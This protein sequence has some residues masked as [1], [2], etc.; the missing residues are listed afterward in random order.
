M[1]QVYRELYRVVRPGGVLV[2]VVGPYV[3]DGK[4]I[5]LAADT[6][7]LCEAAGWTPRERWRHVKRSVSFWRHLHH[8]RDP[9]APVV[10]WEDVLVFAKGEPAWEFAP[11]PETTGPPRYGPAQ[12]ALEV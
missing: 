4:L 9:S 11:L 2:T 3:R 6:I 12:L 10:D 5:D 7:T 8:R 1:Y